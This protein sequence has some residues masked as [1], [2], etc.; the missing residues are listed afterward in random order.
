MDGDLSRFLWENLILTSH[1]RLVILRGLF[2]RDFCL[3]EGQRGQIMNHHVKQ[4]V[5]YTTHFDVC[6]RLQR[7]NIIC[8]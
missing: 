4:F 7:P 5:L 8:Q 3:I 6:L 2:P 1:L